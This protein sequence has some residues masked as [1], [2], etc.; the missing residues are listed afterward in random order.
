MLKDQMGGQFRNGGGIRTDT[1]QILLQ[2]PQ[3][4]QTGF[5]QDAQIWIIIRPEPLVLVCQDKTGRNAL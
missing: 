4:D 2:I 1:F 3:D 5:G